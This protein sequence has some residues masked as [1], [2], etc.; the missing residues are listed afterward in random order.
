METTI[1]LIAGA[2]LIR[3]GVLIELTVDCAV[4]NARF[5]PLHGLPVALFPFD[6]AR[7]TTQ[8]R[9]LVTSCIR[10][11]PQARRASV[12][13]SAAGRCAPAPIR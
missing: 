2:G 9:A 11:M 6:D 3:H 5:A 13:G 7:C 8:I 12:C 4:T 10:K 1:F